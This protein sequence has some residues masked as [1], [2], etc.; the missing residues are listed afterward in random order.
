MQASVGT[1]KHW[2]ASS[3]MLPYSSSSHLDLLSVGPS[4]PCCPLAP[5][6]PS[7]VRKGD[8]AFSRHLF[9]GTL[10]GELVHPDNCKH[11]A[12]SSLA[13][14]KNYIIYISLSLPKFVS[15]SVSVPP[16]I[17]FCS[18]SLRCFSHFLG[19]ISAP[20]LTRPPDQGLALTSVPGKDR[21]V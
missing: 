15:K 14:Y 20:D 5:G 12:I 6:H 16:S 4:A 13:M 17:I 11:L 21:H 19:R 9:G 18:V 1:E 8:H 3:V 10:Q 2:E 7:A